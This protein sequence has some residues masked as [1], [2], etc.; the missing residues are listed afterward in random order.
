MFCKSCGA[1]LK[2]GAEFCAHCGQP[3]DK[4]PAPGPGPGPKRR[5]LI[6][7]AGA[8]VLVA[9]IAAYVLLSAPGA[10][11]A[12]EDSPVSTTPEAVQP[13]TGTSSGT[14]GIQE[15]SYSDGS[16][17]RGEMRNGMRNGTGTL[18]YGDNTANQLDTYTGQWV[19]DQRS[20][21]GK[22]TWKDGS[23]YEGQWK[24]DR[25]HGQGVYTFPSGAI[26]VGTW[27]NGKENGEFTRTMPD[28]TV[29][30]QVYE[31]GEQLSSEKV[32]GSSQGSS[33]ASSPADDGSLPDLGL[34]LNCGRGEDM[35]LDNGSRLVSYSFDLDQGKKVIDDLVDLLLEDRYHL[36]LSDTTE[37]DYISTSALLVN[38][39]D[40]DYTGSSSDIRSVTGWSGHTYDV[41]LSVLYYYDQGRI[42]VT[43]YYSDGFTLTD[44]GRQVSA[45]PTDFSG[46]P[47]NGSSGSSGS[48]GSNIPEFAQRDCQICH[49]SGDC[50]EC[51]GDGY[52]YSSASGEED[53]NCWRC[54]HTGNCWAC[55]GSGKA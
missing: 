48:S 27:E 13:S 37:E 28:G 55:G 22:L 34:F 3:T 36:T 42:G 17:Y 50:P 21:T 44:P 25:V 47:V 14:D 52:L 46:Q 12:A 9:G 39:Y 15:M 49:G 1:Q 8:A 18:V 24:D 54:N 5:L 45:P 6:V 30:R 19:D 16:F 2:D 43:M 10:S 26:L 23:V 33:Q 32:S 41:Q 53:R 11:T 35:A 29:Y 20:G 7:I 38:T 4:S 31:N 40:F 51:G